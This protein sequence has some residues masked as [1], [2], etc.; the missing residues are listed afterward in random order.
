MN[1][2]DGGDGGAVTDPAALER[3]RQAHL[4]KVTSYEVKKKMSDSHKKRCSDP[5]ERQRM[6]KTAKECGNTPPVCRGSGNGQAKLTEEDVRQIR[7]LL[8]SGCS[9]V[10]LAKQFNVTPAVISYIRTRHTWKHVN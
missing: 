4:G 8:K 9:G 2:T 1:G 5:A 10:S 3:I 6:S 7:K